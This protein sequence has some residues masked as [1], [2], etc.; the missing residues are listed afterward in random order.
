MIDRV[1]FISIP[2]KDQGRALEFYTKR[3]G[4]TV[5]TDAPMGPGQRWIE[6]AIPGAQTGLVLFTPPGHEDRVGTM[7][8]LAFESREL[9]KT[10][11][12]LKGKGVEIAQPLQTQPWGT[13]FIFKDP[14][15]NSF[16]VSK[17]A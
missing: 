11:E 17:S 12:E 7:V 14:D 4:F 15:G 2:V 9:E 13:S 16:V 8:N 5:T 6:L 10:F 3:L 1:K